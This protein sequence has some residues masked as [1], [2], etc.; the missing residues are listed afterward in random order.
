MASHATVLVVDDNDMM[1]KLLVAELSQDPALH[2]EQA[3]S[4]YEGLKKAEETHCEVIVLD[5]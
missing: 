2:V 3:S 1:R 4:A 5:M